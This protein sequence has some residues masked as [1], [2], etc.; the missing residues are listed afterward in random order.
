MVHAIVDRV[1]KKIAS[2]DREV[3]RCI[4]KTIGCDKGLG[5]PRLPPTP[6]G[7]H[8]AP[9]SHRRT[10][11]VRVRRQLRRVRVRVCRRCTKSPTTARIT[12]HY[13]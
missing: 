6:W 13:L 12:T 5:A 10:V 1:G 8:R 2:D 9:H 3:C 7:A 11:R 4:R